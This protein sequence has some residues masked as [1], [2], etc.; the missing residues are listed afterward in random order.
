MPALKRWKNNDTKPNCPRCQALQGQ[1]REIGEEFSEG[2][3][4]PPLHPNCDC[5][6]EF[7]QQLEERNR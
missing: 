6:L 7:L 1:T 3:S 2:V 4:A 5:T